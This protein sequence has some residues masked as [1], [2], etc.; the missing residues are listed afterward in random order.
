MTWKRSTI[1]GASSWRNKRGLRRDRKGL[2]A[3]LL[4]LSC[5]FL[6]LSLG[7]I[8]LLAASYLSTP[9]AARQA[10]Q[11]LTDY[12][13]YPVIITSLELTGGTLSI[14]GLRIHNPGGFKE[15]FLS[16]RSITITPDWFALL[17]G[18]NFFREIGPS[19]TQRHPVQEQAGRTERRPTHPQPF[20]AKKGG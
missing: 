10:A 14:S 7:S 19:G 16:C 12:L 4:I 6:C 15:E 8:Y 2:A 17:R 20:P 13:H 18:R 1:R 3:R 9:P 5:V 11:I